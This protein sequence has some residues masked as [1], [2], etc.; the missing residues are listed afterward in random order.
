MSRAW[1][2]RHTKITDQ[3]DPYRV[4]LKTLENQAQAAFDP[5][6]DIIND[7]NTSVQHLAQL[8]KL[9]QQEEEKLQKQIADQEEQEKQKKIALAE[10]ETRQKEIKL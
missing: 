9:A 5:D 7:E 6:E 8:Q 2:F 4:D 1:T 10:A 3:A